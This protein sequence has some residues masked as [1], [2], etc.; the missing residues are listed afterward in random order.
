MLGDHFVNRFDFVMVTQRSIGLWVLFG[1][2]C[3]FGFAKGPHVASGQVPDSIPRN[4]DAELMFEQG[5]AAF[6]RGSFAT[7]A[8][9]FGLVNDYGLNRKTT[10]A[11]VMEAKALL[12]L[13]RYEAA[14]GAIEAL[15][16]RYP[17]TSYRSE[18]E[19]VLDVAR[20]QLR[21]TGARVDTLRI[22][23]VLPMNDK[24]V[25]L[26]QVLFNGMRLAVDKH[27]GL[28]R[29]YVPP[30]MLGP[31]AD[32]FDVARTADVYGDSLAEAAGRTTVTTATDTVWVDSLQIVTEQVRRPNWFAKMYFRRTKGGP[33]DTRKAIDSLIQDDDVDVIVG[34][35]RSRTS[36]VAGEV[37]EEAR[38]LL[39]APL[40][41]DPSVSAGRDYVFQANPTYPMRG[42]VMARFASQSLLI[43]SATIVHERNDAVSGRIAEGFRNEARHQGLIV[44]FTLR[45]D[46]PREW[47]RLPEAIEQDTTITD[48]MFAATDA[49]YI[50]LSGNSASGKIQ[51]ALTG[52]S[53]LNT[54][55]RVLG[56]SEW[57]N[58]TV[59]KE[60]SAFT[61]TY[62]NDFYVQTK[63]RPVQ[64]FIRQ[65]RLLTGQTPD[66]LSA[67]ERRLAYTGYD[68][69][70]FLLRTLPPSG[71][72]PGPADLR[73]GDRYEGLGVR[74]DFSKGNVNRAMYFHRYR[75]NRL[76]LVR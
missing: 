64:D 23:V 10:A 46:S 20:K 61:A 75:N 41:T 63:R 52:L 19:Q 72:K 30:K 44:P 71:T 51:D 73:T 15:L 39:M 22:G 16:S 48:S 54:R 45:L 42:R 6:E 40:A 65:Y 2:L 11:L 58:L 35:I 1:L 31:S 62:A 21:L 32:S 69:V 60:A 7:A 29:R 49:F 26:S 67:D 13:G 76:E 66:Q 38:V 37:A 68:V 4:P 24:N 14:I 74:I 8:E 5:V 57:H 59:R 53:R 27:N 34:P 33:K 36:R 3:V 56:N 17:G 18:A 70:H 47:S 50:P 12:R 43:E 9:R 28:R 25:S 55:A